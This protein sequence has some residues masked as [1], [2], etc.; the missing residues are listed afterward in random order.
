MSSFCVVRESPDS[1]SLG[2]TA[3]SA[4][5]NDPKRP[6]PNHPPLGGRSCVAEEAS[7]HHKIY[8]KMLR[9]HAVKAVLRSR[10]QASKQSD[11]HYPCEV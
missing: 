8:T 6:S 10:R 4:D 9:Q 2:Y 7:Y 1:I 5:E 11:S 3:A